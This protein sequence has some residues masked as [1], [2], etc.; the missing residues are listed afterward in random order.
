MNIE[1]TEVVAL[2]EGAGSKSNNIAA[3]G[4]F[5]RNKVVVA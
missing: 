4:M 1:M 3:F 2:V 5:S